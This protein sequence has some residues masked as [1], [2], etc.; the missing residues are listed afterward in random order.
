MTAEWEMTKI[1]RI[2]RE[3]DK[4]HQQESQCMHLEIRTPHSDTSVFHEHGI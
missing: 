3:K 2:V 1:A 4:K